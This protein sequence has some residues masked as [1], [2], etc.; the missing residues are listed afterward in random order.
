[1]LLGMKATQTLRHRHVFI[2]FCFACHVLRVTGLDI[3][4]IRTW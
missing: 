3:I 2:M 4:L 1:V